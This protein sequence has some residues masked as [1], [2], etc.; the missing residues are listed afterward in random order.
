[1]HSAFVSRIYV[2]LN[3]IFF[4]WGDLGGHITASG[5]VQVC[6]IANRFAVTFVSQFSFSE[7]TEY[8]PKNE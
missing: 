6:H 1:M 7:D 3:V 5:R 8:S 2:D 4:R